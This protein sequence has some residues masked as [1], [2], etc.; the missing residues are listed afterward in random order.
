MPVIFHADRI[1]KI[2]P[3]TVALDQ[4]DFQI[5]RGKVNALIGENG[6]GKSTLVKIL[7]GVEQPSSGRLLLGG[8]EVRFENARDAARLG[9]GMIH[10][11]L[12]LCPNLSV[13]DNVFLGAEKVK[14]GLID[15]GAQERAA[16]EWLARLEEPVPVGAITGDLPLG[17]Q[18]IVEIVKALVRDVRILMMDEPTSALSAAETAVLFRLIRDLT[19]HGV[20]IVYISHRL[21]E[22]LEISDFVTVLRDGR[23]VDEAEA[24]AVDVKWLVEKMTGRTRRE[25]RTAPPAAAGTRVLAAHRISLEAANGR[26]E[27]RDV[28]LDLAAGEIVGVYG[29]MGSGRTELL[30]HLAGLHP[31]GSGEVHLAGAT[32]AGRP[33]HA[34]IRAGVIL[35]PEDRQAAGLVQTLDVRANV[36]LANLA[37]CSTAGHLSRA[38][39]DAA[40]AGLIARLRIKTSGGSQP[41]TALSGGNQQKVVMAKCL[42]A[43]PRLLLL[44]EPTRGVDVGARAEIY[45]AMRSLAAEGM[46]ILFTSSELEEIFAVATRILVLADGR[47]TGDYRAGEADEH[48]L[49]AASTPLSRVAQGGS[50]THG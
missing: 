40:A 28:S 22:L 13:A 7:A 21:E 41:V 38:R 19:A 12:N 36:T 31:E 26:P 35:V 1:T 44:D 48:A 5:R 27:L 45:D 4:V 14:R 34:R 24:A 8:R 43:A 15:R 29:L 11:E 47:I 10:Q 9:I 39:E 23:L 3:G 33:V 46:C 32:L 2:Y 17:Q 18:Q 37:S 6:A 42:L 25:T 16:R 30:E 20:S 50:Q 49:V